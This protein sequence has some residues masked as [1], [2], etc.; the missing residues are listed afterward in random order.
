MRTYSL[1]YPL[2]YEVPYNYSAD[3][4]KREINPLPYNGVYRYSAPPENYYISRDDWDYIPNFLLPDDASWTSFAKNFKH[5]SKWNNPPPQWWIDRTLELL[6]GFAWW[7]S[8]SNEEEYYKNQLEKTKNLAK[9]LALNCILPQQYESYE[10]AWEAE[11]EDDE[12]GMS[13]GGGF[14][15]R[16]IY[17]KQKNKKLFKIIPDKDIK[18]DPKI[19]NELK[20]KLTEYFKLNIVN[21]KNKKVEG[22]LRDHTY[23]D[24]LNNSIIY[25]VHNSEVKMLESEPDPFKKQ[26]KKIR[27]ESRNSSSSA[28]RASTR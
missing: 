17:F 26:L 25:N 23:I 10:I 12:A 16:T 21:S 24:N 2:G 27:E 15:N 11:E 13:Y 3:V 4:K 6:Q 20:H 18:L 9:W 1:T 5:P 19:I 8:G 14:K 22:H 7:K 28:S